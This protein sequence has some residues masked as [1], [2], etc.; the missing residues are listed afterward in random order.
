MVLKP[1]L[2]SPPM[3]F[4]EESTVTMTWTLASADAL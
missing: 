1:V 2:V 3:W 4:D